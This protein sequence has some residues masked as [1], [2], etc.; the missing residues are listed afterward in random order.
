MSIVLAR[1]DN[2]LIHGQVLESWVPATRADCI[3]VAS[4]SLPEQPF[5]KMLMKAA[6]PK[7]IRVEIETVQAAVRLLDSD[8]LASKR[9]MILFANSADSRHA[10]ELGMGFTELNLGNMHGGT[11]KFRV[12]C[13]LALNDED[14]ENLRFLEQ[15]GIDI[16]SQCFPS[17]RKQRWDK[18]V[19]ASIK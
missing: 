3:V 15:D 6:V 8:D 12:T 19:R 11:G 10:H 9:V 14:I 17:D 2:R 1:S 5:Q 4:D 16:V 7:N 18:L 13:T